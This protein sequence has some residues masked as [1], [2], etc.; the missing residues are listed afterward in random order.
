MHVFISKFTFLILRTG[1]EGYHL[2]VGWAAHLCFHQHRDCCRQRSL[3]LL[4]VVIISGV[5]FL[6][7]NILKKMIFLVFIIP[8]LKLIMVLLCSPDSGHQLSAV[9][10]GALSHHTQPFF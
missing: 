2:L 4:Y 10:D 9:P 1:K 5:I 6:N 8:P 3:T 7:Q